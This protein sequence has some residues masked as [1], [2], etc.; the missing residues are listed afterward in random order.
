MSRD[1]DDEMPT[2]SYLCYNAFILHPHLKGLLQYPTI[3]SIL[4][5]MVGGGKFWR[6]VSDCGRPAAVLEM[7]VLDIGIYD[8]TTQSLKGKWIYYQQNPWNPEPSKGIIFF[9]NDLINSP[10]KALFDNE[11]RAKQ[12]YEACLTAYHNDSMW[13]MEVENY[14]ERMRTL[15]NRK[16]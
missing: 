11:E 6:T 7:D 5:A 12:Y 14:R 1:K 13:Q 10:E 15:Y 9:V 8:G 3:N 2:Y 16:G 4:D